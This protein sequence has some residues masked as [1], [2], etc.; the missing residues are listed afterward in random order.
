ML[1]L[2]LN[3]KNFLFFKF[4]CKYI[5]FNWNFKIFSYLIDTQSSTT[6]PIKQRI[7]SK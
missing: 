7:F 3:I 4:L 1:I 5:Q 2:F 6:Y